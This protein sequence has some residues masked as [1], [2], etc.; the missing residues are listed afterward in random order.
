MR[1]SLKSVASIGIALSV[2]TASWVLADGD[3]DRDGHGWDHHRDVWEHHDKPG[4]PGVRPVPEANAGLAL[5]PVLGLFAV[6]AAWKSSKQAR[7]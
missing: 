3:H 2:A 7:T 6:G 4:K 1:Y 5:L